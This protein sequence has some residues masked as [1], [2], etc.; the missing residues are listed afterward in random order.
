MRI[1]ISIFAGLIFQLAAFGQSAD[2]R[3]MVSYNEGLDKFLRKDYKDAISAFSWA[4]RIDSGFLQAYE[5]RGVSKYY[6]KDF[7]GAIDD[8]DKA[9]KI[10]PNDWNTYGRRGWAKFHIQDFPGAID[11]FSRAIEGALSNAQYYNGRGQAKYSLGYYDEAIADFT[12]VI[13]QWSADRIHKRTAW[14]WRGLSKARSGHTA[15][16]CR[17]FQKAYSL[18]YGKAAELIDIY[19]NDMQP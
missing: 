8:F 12:R 4:I 14:F 15:S 11:D 3:A 18:G 19:C 13:R 6:L 2:R 7:R 17:D 10:N 5:N 1:L 16:A 9:L